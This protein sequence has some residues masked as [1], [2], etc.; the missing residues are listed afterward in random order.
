[1]AATDKPSKPKAHKGAPKAG[2]RR[3]S[4]KKSGPQ[5]LADRLRAQVAR[6]GMWL[7]VCIAAG[8]FLG[9]T[10]V[11]MLRP[12]VVAYRPG[13][14][15]PG[16]VTSRVDFF[17]HD[18]R[19]L[20]DARRR[21]RENEPRVYKAAAPAAAAAPTP[22]SVPPDADAA[23][24]API[25]NRLAADLLGLP[26]AVG[27]QRLEQLAPPLR[28]ILDNATLA[29]LQSYAEQFPRTGWD[30]AVLGYVEGLRKLNP[31]IVPADARAADR[32]RAI[33]L[34]GRG[35]VAVDDSVYTPQ[36]ADALAAKLNPLAADQFEDVI[37]PKIVAYTLAQL[38]PTYVPDD[39]GTADARNKAADRVPASAGEI[40]VKRN[41]PVIAAGPVTEADWQRLQAED[42]AYHA[43]NGGPWRERL[44]LAC[45]AL[46]LTTA[47]SAYVV[48]Y[49]PRVLVNHGRAVAIVGLLLGMLALAQLAAVTGGRIYVF[50]VLPTVLVA[51]ILAIAYDQRSAIGIATI[52]GLF[53]TVALGEGFGFFL[54]LEVGILTACFLLD[55]VRTRGKLIE[56]GGATALTMM[57]ASL[58]VGL[59]AP[60]PMLL[61]VQSTLYTGA[62]A[63]GAGFL[64]LGVLPEIEK[65]FRITTAMSLLELA[66]VS[67]PLLRKLAMDAPGTYNHSL[68]VATLAEEAAEAIGADA[69]LCRVAAYFHDAGK[70][71]K[72]D[73]FVEN[74]VDGVN[75]H[76]NLSPS[77][78]LLIIIGH[79][80]DG[81][82]LAREWN[83]P[84]KLFPFIQSHHGT[85]RVEY[86]YHQA[87][88]GEAERLLD[89]DRTV[90]PVSETQYRYPGPK[91]K[92]KE[93]A[94][95]MLSDCCESATRAMPEPNA[96]RIESLVKELS[97]KRL[98][99][100]QFDDCDLT[101]AELERVQRSLVKTLIGIYHGRI[102]YPSDKPSEEPKPE[103]PAARI[104]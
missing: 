20:A 7:S 49:Q 90:T 104:A 48:V 92:S 63:L 13:Q 6:K 81:I 96:G 75:R 74:Q 68:Q 54:T 44:G 39:L 97:M 73:Y 85:T 88:K 12:Q 67:H 51:M 66:D 52:H 27:G 60:D 30:K 33:R 35:P 38:G 57:F 29:R 5:P 55:E 79:V 94:I 64:V 43:A 11:L 36:M 19:E 10:L 16:D 95:L 8:F 15:A 47:L 71:N 50:A 23:G 62:A 59:M 34:P 41:M 18:P 22:G 86:F 89:G 21:A 99:D 82:E 100:G 1:M 80:K 61:V 69:L 76:L 2:T 58:A 3:D 103:L 84:T 46:I 91:P 56:V 101:M 26:D 14:Y 25:Y 24:T 77:V 40:A 42:A 17:Y 31:V 37:Y 70:L 45:I 98:L 72:A 28:K 53:V 93:V 83:L 9:S 87:K 102:A 65:R 78:S 32:G 4:A